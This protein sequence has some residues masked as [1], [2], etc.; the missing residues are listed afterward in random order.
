MVKRLLACVAVFTVAGV[1]L[2]GCGSSGAAG[3]GSSKTLKVG[4]LTDLTGPASSGYA[5]T[6][7]GVKAFLAG[8]PRVDGMKI[9]YIMA[10]TT[11]TP[12][13]A[14]TAVQ[15]LVEKDHVFAILEHSIVYS[16][17]QAYALQ[18]GIPVVGSAIDGPEWTDPKNTNLF[19]ALGP[20]NPE[21]MLLAQGQFMK[22]QGVTRC[23]SIGYNSGVSAQDAA[24]AFIKSCEAAG[25]QNGYLNTQVPFG[26]TNVAPI[27]L[28]IKNAHV[29]GLYLPIVPSTAFALVGAVRQLGVKMKSILLASGYGG[30]LLASK[31]TITAAQGVDF[32][33]DIGVPEEANT[34]ATRRLA[35]DFAKVGITGPPTAA[36]QEI[37]LVMTAFVAGMKAA[38][39]NPTPAAFMEALRGVKNYDADGLLAPQ[40]LNFARFAPQNNCMWVVRL[41]GEKF[42]VLPGAPF[43]GPIKKFK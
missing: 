38:G 12:T 7:K 13:G 29:D 16:G 36:E 15:K 27:A 10:D 28:A 25:L 21:Y 35:A 31:A 42:H 43:C 39:R 19:A 3:G 40:R 4:V 14:L 26:S 33:T 20:I 8:T 22:A 37:Y 9:E 24:E 6:E 2:S 34:A 41:Q 30:D 1:G 32:A 17:A 18:H 11:S 5:T 23:A